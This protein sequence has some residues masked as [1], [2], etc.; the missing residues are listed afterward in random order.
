MHLLNIHC[1]AFAF[2]VLRDPKIED[3]F[4]SP[5]FVFKTSA[6]SSTTWGCL[7]IGCEA[8]G[9]AKG[10]MHWRWQR[11]GLKSWTHPCL[12]C[13]EGM[14]GPNILLHFTSELNGGEFCEQL[15]FKREKYRTIAGMTRGTDR[16]GLSQISAVQHITWGCLCFSF[17]FGM[18]TNSS[19]LEFSVEQILN[20]L[21]NSL[22][23]I[24]SLSGQITPAVFTRAVPLKGRHG[25][26]TTFSP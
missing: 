24:S 2:P 17:W 22:C 7:P 20:F 18:E 26:P 16:A 10:A 13:F 9:I 4:F 5:S 15:V 11:I 21:T 14:R 19:A 25:F 23:K 8:P 1:A 3:G 6:T 12:Q